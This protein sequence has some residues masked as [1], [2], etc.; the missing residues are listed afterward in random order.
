[1]TSI[2]TWHKLTDFKTLKPTPPQ[3][4]H[5]VISSKADIILV[6]FYDRAKKAAILA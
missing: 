6:F 5:R 2:A 4:K 1:M 3:K